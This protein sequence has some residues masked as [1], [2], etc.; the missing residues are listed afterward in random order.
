VIVST[1]YRNKTKGYFVDLASNDAVS[2]SNTLGLEKHLNWTGKYFVYVSISLLLL[3]FLS[4]LSPPP[5]LMPNNGSHG[6][7]VFC[8]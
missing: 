6:S 8:I 3:L 4:L 5:M 1:L 2:L 7:A